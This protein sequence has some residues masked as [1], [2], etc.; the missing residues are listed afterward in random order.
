MLH[1]CSHLTLSFAGG[2]G[3]CEGAVVEQD[4]HQYVSVWSGDKS[5]SNLALGMFVW[6]TLWLTS[7]QREATLV[8]NWSSCWDISLGLQMSWCR[9]PLQGHTIPTAA[10]N[11]PHCRALRSLL[12]G[13][14]IPTAGL[15]YPYCSAILS[16]IQ[17][18]AADPYSRFLLQISNTDPT[19][20]SYCR[21]RL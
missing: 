19:A 10:P 21:T 3:G 20:Y 13:H 2:G 1:C 16:P 7:V 14:T 12:Q 8:I 17:G 9:F 18:P 11:Y 6:A 15:Y 4:W 5:P